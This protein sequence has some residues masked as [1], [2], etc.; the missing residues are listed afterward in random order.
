MLLSENGENQGCSEKRRTLKTCPGY[1][2]NSTTLC[3]VLFLVKIVVGVDGQARRGEE[4]LLV[5]GE[6]AIEERLHWWNCSCLWRWSELKSTQNPTTEDSHCWH[7]HCERI[8]PARPSLINIKT[9]FVC[10][11]CGVYFVIMT[12]WCGSYDFSSD[13]PFNKKCALCIVTSSSFAKTQ[14]GQSC[15]GTCK[16]IGLLVCNYW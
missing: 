3:C 7:L 4:E 11:R 15:N 9:R 14:S 13:G 5:R 2:G 16:A 6:I 12:K 1:S 8:L 10:N